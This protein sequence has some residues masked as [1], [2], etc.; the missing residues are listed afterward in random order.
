MGKNYRWKLLLAPQVMCLVGMTH[1]LSY[2]SDE[3]RMLNWNDVSRAE[4]RIVCVLYGR[5]GQGGVGSRLPPPHGGDRQSVSDVGL[6][7]MP[8]PPL[9][10]P[11]RRSLSDHF[12]LPPAGWF[13]SLSRPIKKKFS[14]GS[15]TS[16]QHPFP[17]RA[18]SA[19]DI[20][21][22]MVCTCQI[23]FGALI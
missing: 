6:G 3:V 21:P 8:P 23:V 10:P 12:K 5:P 7:R 22:N 4:G 2:K 11:T 13:A 15:A 1:H 20:T 17:R 18:K 9:P 14:S 16:G 19:W